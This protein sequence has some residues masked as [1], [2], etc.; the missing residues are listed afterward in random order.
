MSDVP[1]NVVNVNDIDAIDHYSGPHWGQSYKPL[2]PALDRFPGRLGM[3]LTRVLP[4]HSG[5]PFHAHQREDEICYVLSGRGVFRYGET[6]REIGPGDC[7]A[8]PAGTGVAHQIANPFDEDLVFLAIG[9]N[10]PHEVAVYPDS[11]KVMVRSLKQVGYL[12]TADY[13]DGEPDVP[14]IF[15]LAQELAERSRR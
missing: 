15:A 4:G 6:I 7:M 9:P 13:N 11:G 12:R 2:T 8:C 14:R 3:N 1:P 5:C 10:D